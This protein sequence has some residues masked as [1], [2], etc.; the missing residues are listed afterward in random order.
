MCTRDSE[1]QKMIDA[2][3]REYRMSSAR[4]LF[5]I[6]MAQ[7]RALVLKNRLNTPALF[8]LPGNDLIVDSRTSAKVFHSL[9]LKDKKI[10]QYPDMHHA[11]SIDLGKEQVFRDILEWIRGS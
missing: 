11:L 8:L 9:K 10:I 1:Y 4:L 3:N 5:K 7:L 6:L 2:D